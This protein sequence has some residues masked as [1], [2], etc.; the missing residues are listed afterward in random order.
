MYISPG[1][2]PAML[3]CSTD[4]EL[5]IRKKILDRYEQDYRDYVAKL[6]AH[7]PRHSR[8]MLTLSKYNGG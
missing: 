1:D 7:Y 5:T 6:L 2:L 8:A 4:N 3:D